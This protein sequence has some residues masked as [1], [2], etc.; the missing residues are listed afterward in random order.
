MDSRDIGVRDKVDVDLKIHPTASLEE[1]ARRRSGNRAGVSRTANAHPLQSAAIMTHTRAFGQ[2][3]Q[4]MPRPDTTIFLR[5]AVERIVAGGA[6]A[7][8]GDNSCKIYRMPR[9]LSD[10]SSLLVRARWNCWRWCVSLRDH[11][12]LLDPGHQPRRADRRRG[13]RRT[14]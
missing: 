11:F 3:R 14:V 6:S 7:S 8:A 4:M 1:R 12:H 9:S 5:G 13:A 2:G 10:R